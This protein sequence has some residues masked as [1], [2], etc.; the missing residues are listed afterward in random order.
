LNIIN[1]EKNDKATNIILVKAQYFGLL[2]RK[3]KIKISQ[4]NNE[5]ENKIDLK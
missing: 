2:K 3:F 5:F 4:D 1:G